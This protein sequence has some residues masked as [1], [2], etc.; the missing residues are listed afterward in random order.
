[1]YSRSRTT[2]PKEVI[3]YADRNAW[4]YSPPNRD[5]KPR[6]EART[7]ISSKV[8]L[9]L[10]SKY[11]TPG[12]S[13]NVHVSREARLFLSHKLSH[14]VASHRHPYFPYPN[15]IVYFIT[16]LSFQKVTTLI[17]SYIDN[18]IFIVFPIYCVNVKLEVGTTRHKLR[19]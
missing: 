6:G 15:N 11:Q 18:S 5:L 2:Y 4:Y 16:F 8:R 19:I 12:K 10:H 9:S 7:L 13:L 14:R 3:E 1:M 17:N